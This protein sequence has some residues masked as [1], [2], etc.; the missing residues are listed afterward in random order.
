[1]PLE[2][3]HVVFEGMVRGTKGGYEVRDVII[4]DHVLEGALGPP[5]AD[6]TRREL[7]GSVLRIEGDLTKHT[8]PP[9]KDSDEPEQ[10]RSGTWFEA[11]R[12]DS[13]KVAKPAEV[14][15]GT[16]ARSKGFY[17]IAGRLVS[18]EDFERYLG[19]RESK[20]SDRARLYGQPRT[21]HCEPNAQCLVGGSLPLFDVARAEW[22]P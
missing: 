9:Q 16:L 8:T 20:P 6:G 14:I 15:E 17:S 2:E 3:G 12:I 4:D 7:L 18:H 21:V 19:R 22:L 11:S 1:M 5:G 13:A 10:M